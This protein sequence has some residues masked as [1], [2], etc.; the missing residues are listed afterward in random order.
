MKGIYP[1]YNRDTADVHLPY[2]TIYSWQENL[3]RREKE[4]EEERESKKCPRFIQPGACIDW[5]TEAVR[6]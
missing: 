2:T 3:K 6:D 5:P 4:K 1:E